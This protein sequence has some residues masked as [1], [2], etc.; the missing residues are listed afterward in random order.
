MLEKEIARLT[1]LYHQKQQ[2]EQWP[3]QQ[4]QKQNE[5]Q[6]YST[7]NLSISRGV[8]SQMTNLYI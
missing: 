7:H 4:K 2:Q 3:R 8:E 1:F 5:Q 6:N